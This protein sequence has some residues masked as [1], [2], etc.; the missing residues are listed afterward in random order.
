M[1]SSSQQLAGRLPPPVPGSAV[2][3]DRE[4]EA[5][6]SLA[7]TALPH[8]APGDPEDSCFPCTWI[9]ADTGSEFHWCSCKIGRRLPFWNFG[10]FFFPPLP[11][12]FPL[13]TYSLSFVPEPCYAW[14]GGWP[15]SSLGRP[16]T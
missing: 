5:C 10:C 2:R 16:G 15:G 6:I 1:S 9:L 8:V 14:A 12:F 13:K 3:R 4:A 7:V 11:S